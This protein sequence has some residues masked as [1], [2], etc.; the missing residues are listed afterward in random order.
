M[1]TVTKDRDYYRALRD[2][3]LLLETKESVPTH[4]DWQELAIVLAERLKDAE[5]EVKEARYN[6]GEY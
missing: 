1:T 2:E 3:E 4:V 6:R 5:W